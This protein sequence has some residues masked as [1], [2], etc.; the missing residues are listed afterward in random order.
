MRRI[1]SI[2][3]LCGL[4]LLPVAPAFGHAD[5]VSMEPA[6]GAVLQQ[7]P[8]RVV[9]GFSE[10]INPLGTVVVVIDPTGVQIQDGEAVVE[11]Q[12]VWVKVRP[13]TEPGKYRV[14][15]RI[16]SA[17][18]HAVSG[19][20][21]FTFAPPGVAL[22]KESAEASVH[23]KSSGISVRISVIMFIIAVAMVAAG[24]GFARRRR[25]L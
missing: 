19:T 8:D 10:K 17:D 9:L 6:A 1:R 7:S 20:R 16:V 12:R 25:Q 11:L 5:Q 24:L 21:S 23:A 3:L 18:G 4:F 14:N 22:P 15:Y 2:V 13:F